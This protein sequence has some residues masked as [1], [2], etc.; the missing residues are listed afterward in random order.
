MDPLNLC[1]L[2]NAPIKLKLFTV[3]TYRTYA[4]YDMNP[5][6]LCLQNG[7]IKL[8]LFTIYNVCLVY[9]YLVVEKVG[10]A[11]TVNNVSLLGLSYRKI[12]IL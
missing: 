7:P 9:V 6:N 3:W 4:V 10:L 8:K 2:W 1:R 5:S 12:S 11:H